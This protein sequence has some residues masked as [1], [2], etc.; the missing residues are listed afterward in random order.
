VPEIPAGARDVLQRL[1]AA[2]VLDIL[3]ISFSIYW[4]LLLLRGTTAMTVLRGAGVLLVAAFLLSRMLDL[5]VLSFILR[6][7]V[8]GL[9]IAMAIIFQP[10][11]RRALERVGRTGF[12][13]VLRRE[14]HRHSVDR[15]RRAATQLARLGYGA[16]I[17]LERD[18]GLQDVIDT[19]IPLRAEISVELL[20][21]IFV[22]GAPLHDGAVIVSGNTVVAAGCTL[23]LSESRLPSEYGMRHRAALGITESTDAVVVI[24]SEEHGEISL[25]SN[26][27]MV[28]ELDEERLSRQLH[29]LFALDEDETAVETV[30]GVSA[31]AAAERRAS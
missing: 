23:T 19:G 12:R 2:A 31:D 4:L 13:S 1:D 27:R 29:R 15:V 5:Q 21:G 16:L 10:E 25:A 30:R 20:T 9:V 24:V 26:G 7:S 3:I 11:I 18:T 22:P 6:S 14:E 28:T 17:V 8:A